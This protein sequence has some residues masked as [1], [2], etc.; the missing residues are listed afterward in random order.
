LRIAG[1]E[2]A[3]KGALGVDRK[4]MALDTLTLAM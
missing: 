2:L 3:V 1:N 4:A